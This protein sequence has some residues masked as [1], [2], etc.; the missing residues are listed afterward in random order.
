[1][2]LV[3]PL[4]RRPTHLYMYFCL[5]YLLTFVVNNFV[6]WENKVGASWPP[7]DSL[8]Q[9]YISS[10]ILFRAGTLSHVDYMSKW[11][12]VVEDSQR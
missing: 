7:E 4:K 2:W 1:M 8:Q 5:W 6:F 10:L 12:A 11:V 3:A 9:K